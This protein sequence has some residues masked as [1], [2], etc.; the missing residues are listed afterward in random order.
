MHT[1]PKNRYFLDANILISGL[2]WN[3]NERKLL[4]LG[5]SRRIEL[6][7]SV[8]VLRELQDVFT[9]FGFSEQKTAESM[10][11]LRNFTEL[12]DATDEEVAVCRN[13]LDDKVDVP[14][15]AT[16]IKSGSILVTGDK[17]LIRQGKKYLE[18]KTTKEILDS[19]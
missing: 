5:E 7:S 8:Y 16:A 10:V 19:L 1:M 9:G 6:I 13:H 2:L 3:G 17:K 14:I 12:V 18:V 11:Y 15:L 4:L